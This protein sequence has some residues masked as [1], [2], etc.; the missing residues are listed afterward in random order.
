MNSFMTEFQNERGY[1]KRQNRIKYIS[2]SGFAPLQ[3]MYVLRSEFYTS[4][5]YGGKYNDWSKAISANFR[6][7]SDPVLPA[8]TYIHE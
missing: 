8:R 2:A 4:V 3:V 6:R 5:V 1:R 7:E